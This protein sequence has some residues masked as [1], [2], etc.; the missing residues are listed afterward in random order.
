MLVR[1]N[2]VHLYCLVSQTFLL[3]SVS[4]KCLQAQP[5]NPTSL[6]AHHN[7][8]AAN[9]PSI[10]NR[11]IR[12][13]LTPVSGKPLSRD[14]VF[15]TVVLPS[16]QS[17]YPPI[18]LMSRSCLWVDLRDAARLSGA[19]LLTLQSPLSLPAE[20]DHELTPYGDCQAAQNFTFYI[21]IGASP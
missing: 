5:T 13:K 3:S 12:Q 8:D 4:P 10:T 14:C 11:Q 16:K 6:T 15:P 20:L 2:C 17:T 18:S 21:N 7:T 19:L 1:K 9:S